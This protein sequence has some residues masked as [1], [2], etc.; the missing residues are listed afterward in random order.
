MFARRQCRATARMLWDYAARTLGEPDIQR[1]E[2]HLR[3]CEACRTE[4]AEY[5]RAFCLTTSVRSDDPP[6]SQ[7]GWRE[8]R[9]VLEGE[10][11]PAPAAAIA[12]APRLGMVGMAAAGVLV[13]ILV[14]KMTLQSDPYALPPK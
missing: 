4:A 11:R 10:R 12:V 14:H 13:A 8:L 5:A 6:A 7:R 2:G 9:A 1:V 3:V